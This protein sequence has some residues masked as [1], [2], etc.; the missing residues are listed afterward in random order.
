M[1]HLNISPNQI[2]HLKNFGLRFIN[3]GEGFDIFTLIPEDNWKLD[4]YKEFILTKTP[5]LIYRIPIMVGQFI[6][7]GTSQKTK[8]IMNEENASSN[9][10]QL[11]GSTRHVDL[12]EIHLK[13]LEYHAD[14][15]SRDILHLIDQKEDFEFL[16]IKEIIY[17][18]N[19]NG[20]R[21]IDVTRGEL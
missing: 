8:Y 3:K 14:E 10:W 16:G 21:S 13:S 4:E 18:N 1:K 5:K 20:H 12:S 15:L 7:I 19:S 17:T 2:N 9:E 11:I 6:Y